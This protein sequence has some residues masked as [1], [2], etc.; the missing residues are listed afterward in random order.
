[1]SRREQNCYKIWLADFGED[2]VFHIVCCNFKVLVEGPEPF[3]D[4]VPVPP[5][6]VAP[7]LEQ[8]GGGNVVIEENFVLENVANHVLEIGELTADGIVVDD[9]GPAPENAVPQPQEQGIVGEW[10]KQLVC[11]C[12]SNTAIADTLGKW[13]GKTWP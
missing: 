11:I 10:E 4:E 5:V 2:T 7:G 3:K 13:K 8:L 6:V 1:M 9:E 12:R